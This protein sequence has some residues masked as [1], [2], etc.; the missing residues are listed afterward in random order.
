MAISCGPSNRRPRHGQASSQST[1]RKET[2]TQTGER[3]QVRRRQIRL[4][5]RYLK[6]EVYPPL[7]LS[8]QSKSQKTRWQKA[9]LCNYLF[10]IISFIPEQPQ[11]IIRAPPTGIPCGAQLM[12]TPGRLCTFPTANKVIISNESHSPCTTVMS[13]IGF[14][15]SA[16]Q[17]PDCHSEKRGADCKIRLWI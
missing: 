12:S 15:C 14:I 1:W 16:P 13:N 17:N 3:R 8:R 11:Q 9:A 6:M 10:T 5:R 7:A 4:T 2:E